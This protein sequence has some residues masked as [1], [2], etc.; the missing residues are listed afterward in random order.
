MLKRLKV[1]PKVLVVVGLMG[2]VVA[3]T[4]GLGLTSL[5]KIMSGVGEM[6]TSSDSL[7]DASRAMAT[8]LNMARNVQMLTTGLDEHTRKHVEAEAAEEH[9][10]VIE[11]L[12]HVAENAVTDAEKAQVAAIRKAFAEYE[13]YYRAVVERSRSGGFDAAAAAAGDGGALVERIYDELGAVQKVQNART[14]AAIENMNVVHADTRTHLLTVSGLGTGGGM[15]LALVVAIIGLARPVVRLTRAMRRLAEGDNAVDVPGLDRGDEIGEMAH[16]VEVFKR[17]GEERQRLEA[18]QEAGRERERALARQMEEDAVGHLQGIVDIAVR[19]NE[20]FFN[21]AGLTAE[22]GAIAAD[23]Q[24]MAAAAEEMVASSQEISSNTGAADERSRTAAATST[25]GIQASDR[26]MEAMQRITGAIEQAARSVDEL[27]TTSGEIGGL[28]DS[29]EAIASQTNLLALNATIEAARAGDAGK[30]FAVVAHE[31]KQLANQTARVTDDIRRHIDSLKDEM[32]KIAGVMNGSADAV[33]QGAGTLADLGHRMEDIKA[34]TGEASQRMGEIAG[35][36][37]QQTATSTEIA[38]AITRIADR[39]GSNS[40]TVQT[41]LDVMDAS[42]AVVNQRVEV[43]AKLGTDLAIV[44][45]AKKDHGVFKNNI[46]SCVLGRKKLQVSEV[47]DHHLCRFGKWYDSVQEPRIKDSA[48]YRG[49]AAPH[50]RVHSHG[51]AAVQLAA[52]DRTQEALQQVRLM[53]EASREVLECLDAISKVVLQVS[54]QA[55][56]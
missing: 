14:T 18:E 3:A 49:I 9:A 26:A 38:D 40:N 45:M 12:G 15:A 19:S 43:F 50:E 5:G 20:V 13:S 56:A 11:E 48:A 33:R 35:I 30:G 41:V 4:A 16:A 25:E 24:A 28:V 21:L 17:A 51:R 44:E 46:V 34:V 2:A 1:L 22:I 23:T 31:V 52:E 54:G 27:T 29:V 36:I 53:N 37:D 10:K 55:A 32:T 8:L 7:Y 6:A 47:A 42:M 39:A